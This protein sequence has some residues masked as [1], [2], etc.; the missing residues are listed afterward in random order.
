MK[1]RHGSRDLAAASP[2]GEIMKITSITLKRNG[3]WSEVWANVNGADVLLIREIHDNEF[4]HTIT[5]TGI[6]ECLDI[7]RNRITLLCTIGRKYGRIN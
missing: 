7:H 5:D 1:Y 4:H 6:D 3:V 2:H